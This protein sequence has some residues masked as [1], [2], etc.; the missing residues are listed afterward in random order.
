MSA[1]YI[2][3]EVTDENKLKIWGDITKT[4]GETQELLEGEITIQE[5]AGMLGVSVDNARVKMLSLINE[6]KVTWRWHVEGR[7]KR[8][9]VY[10]PTKDD[11]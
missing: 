9:K 3:V 10:L 8:I 2:A 6:G 5:F 11:A 1:K 4:F 7:Y